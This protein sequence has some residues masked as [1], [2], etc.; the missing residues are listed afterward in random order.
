MTTVR[1]YSHR[2]H[3][4]DPR[5]RTQRRPEVV[6]GIFVLALA[7]IVILFLVVGPTPYRALADENPYHQHHKKPRLPKPPPPR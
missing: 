3:S 2:R 1:Q 6:I 5:S 4:R 7:I